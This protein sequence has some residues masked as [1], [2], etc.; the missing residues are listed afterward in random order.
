[1]PAEW[2]PHEATWLS[3]PHDPVTW[4]ERVPQVEKVFQQM[5]K[6][7]S[8]NERVDLL[9]HDSTTHEKVASW[10]KKDAVKNVRIHDIG[11]ADSWI[12]DYG[13][14]F[15]TREGQGRREA[16]YTD[17]IFNAWGDKYEEL[18]R[19]DDI[20]KRLK[21]TIGEAELFEP[22]IVLEGGSI[23]VNGEGTLLTTEQ[24]LLNKNRNPTLGSGEIEGYLRAFLGVSNI[25]WL[26]DGIEG[27]DTDGHI[28]DIARFVDPNTVLAASEPDEEDANHRPL[29]ENLKRLRA[30]SD[31]DGRRLR[32]VELPMPGWH[33]DDEGRLPASYANFYIANGVVL[34]PV[35]G[36]ANDHKAESIVGTLFPDRRIVPIDCRDL[37][38]GFGAIHCVTQ[39]QPAI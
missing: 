11:T 22:G 39:Q 10:L 13:P 31:Q 21:A 20:P 25:L 8:P 34:L 26:S 17:W 12:R 29:A 19:D 6:A 32:V 1:M 4:P 2:G 37:V 35:F 14:I 15:L 24:C 30:M 38:F 28:D 16:C 7:L 3:W 36:H 27:D 33:G 23:D 9:V 5:I 18:K